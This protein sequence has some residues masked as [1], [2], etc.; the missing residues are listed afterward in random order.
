MAVKRLL[1]NFLTNQISELATIVG[2]QWRWI[3][4]ILWLDGQREL[5]V[6]TNKPHVAVFN[7]QWLEKQIDLT[8]IYGVFWNRNYYTLSINV[9]NFHELILGWGGSWTLKRKKSLAIKGLR[10]LD[11]KEIWLQH[12]GKWCRVYCRFAP[13]FSCN[14]SAWSR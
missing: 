2:L 1:F 6:S 7:P 8:W 12:F 4:S 13:A 3:F 11:A 14:Q 5:L 9:N 10:T